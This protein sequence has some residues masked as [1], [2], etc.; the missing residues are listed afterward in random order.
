[1][2]IYK[3]GHWCDLRVLKCYRIMFMPLAHA[4]AL[5]EAVHT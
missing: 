2:F 4:N 1:M 3:L 5:L